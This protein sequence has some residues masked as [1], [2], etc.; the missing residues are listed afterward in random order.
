MRGS[1]IITICMGLVF[2]HGRMGD[3]ILS[4]IMTT[5]NKVMGYIF[6]MMGGSMRG[7]GIKGSNV[8]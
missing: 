6:G 3:N 1:G 5:R 4:S 7:I 2:T 8:E